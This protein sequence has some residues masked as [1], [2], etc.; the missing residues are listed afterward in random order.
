MKGNNGI[1]GS[2]F[3]KRILDHFEKRIRLFDTINNHFA[4]KKP[5]TRMFRIR[6]SHVKTFDIGGITTE[7]FL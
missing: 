3:G 4:T 2:I 7:F 5:M 6:L 1:G